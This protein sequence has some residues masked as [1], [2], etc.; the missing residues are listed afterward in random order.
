M[1]IQLFIK[2]KITEIGTSSCHFF[3]NIYVHH[4]HTKGRHYTFVIV[5]GLYA[6]YL[7]GIIGIRKKNR[8]KTHNT[9][10]KRKWTKGQTT[11]YKTLHIKLKIE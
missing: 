2:Y 7:L 6:Q 1:C 9:M 11:I 4:L 3:L 8:R 5:R 10:T